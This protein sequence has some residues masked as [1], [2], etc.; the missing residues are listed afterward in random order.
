[1]NPIL[2]EGM[3]MFHVSLGKRSIVRWRAKLFACRSGKT[4]EIEPEF[5]RV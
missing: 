5:L 4:A 2:H 3:H 1:M